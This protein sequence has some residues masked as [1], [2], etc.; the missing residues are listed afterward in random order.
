MTI[1]FYNVKDDPRVISKTVTQRVYSCD[2][3]IL[4][5]CNIKKPALVLTYDPRL[6]EANYFYIAEWHRYYFMGEP[7]LSPGRRC[8][9]EGQEDV[10]FSSKDEIL[11]L[12]AYCSRCE[13]KAENYA[14]DSAPLSLVTSVVTN[15][16]FSGHVFNA[17]G[18]Q[19]QYLLTV[20][21]GKLS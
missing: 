13:S 15:L 3:N 16:Q 1:D 2:A 4:G 21:G 17:N 8:I 9:I 14:V 19:R 10:L 18:T 7:T 11:E 12:Y 6:L 20:K 5:N